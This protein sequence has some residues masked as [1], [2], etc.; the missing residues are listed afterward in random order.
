M[1]CQPGTR[2]RRVAWFPSR[3]RLTSNGSEPEW[4]ALG[5]LHCGLRQYADPR[6]HSACGDD[7]NACTR[8]GRQSGR[9]RSRRTVCPRWT[10]NPIPPRKLRIP[11]RL[12]ILPTTKRRGPER[13]PQARRSFWDRGRRAT[14]TAHLDG[15]KGASLL[16]YPSSKVTQARPNHTR[17]GSCH[18]V[19]R[20]DVNRQYEGGREL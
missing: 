6:W 5:V 4:T 17:T 3:R 19:A 8:I 20:R 1:G 11:R 16:R 12:Q 7:S 10:R 18:R 2:Q 9:A 13:Y 14:T 15:S